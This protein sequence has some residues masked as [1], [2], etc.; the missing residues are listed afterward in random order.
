M[1]ISGTELYNPFAVPFLKVKVSNWKVKKQKLLEMAP[2]C[3]EDTDPVNG[4]YKSDYFKYGGLPPYFKSFHDVLSD[5]L[6]EIGNY[7]KD[8]N[9]NLPV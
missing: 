8:Q 6:N 1:K 3:I 5:E 7:F 4:G 2:L 9:E